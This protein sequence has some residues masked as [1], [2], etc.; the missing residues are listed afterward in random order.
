MTEKKLSLKVSVDKN[1][2]V[3][4]MRRVVEVSIQAP[5]STKIKVRPP[6]NLALVIDRS[7]SMS[8]R[9]L[10]YAKMAAIHLLDSLNEHDRISVVAYDDHITVIE[11]GCMANP[12]AV[13]IIRQRIRELSARGSTDLGG[14]WM[15]GCQCVA[16][17]QLPEGVNRVLLLTDGLANVGMTNREEL[18]THA[19]ELHSRGVSTTTFGV[20]A[21][22]DEHLL[23]HMANMGGGNFYFIK[24][25]S[26]IPAFFNEEFKELS[27]ITA[28]QV[29]IEVD[30]PAGVSAIIPGGWKTET[31]TNF[32]RVSL[33]DL[34][35]GCTREVYLWLTFPEQW[36]AANA[37]LK[38]TARGRGSNS[39]V[40]EEVSE[41]TFRRVEP[42]EEDALPYDRE[43]M[44]RF[45]LVMMS[46][47]TSAALMMDRQGD[48]DGARQMLRTSLDAQRDFMCI[49]DVEKIEFLAEKRIGAM[50]PMEAKDE[51]MR[52]YRNKQR[53]G[54]QPP[55][56]DKPDQP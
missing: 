44:E 24:S 31:S 10:E 8:D 52:Y 29:A 1:L 20:G 5:V 46:D 48:F 41:I 51:Q 30:L 45:S 49:E 3:P 47:R 35:S 54:P 53:R 4:G 26:Q 25:P 19:R 28:R 50:S 9:K 18:G 23:E 14:G 55:E 22:F 21:D 2:F 12:A 17:Q 38:I 13:A 39:G 32:A 16:H 11:E 34:P 33:G 15:Q 7:G 40:M 42:A 6:L 37:S 43:L 56:P 27:T 36:D